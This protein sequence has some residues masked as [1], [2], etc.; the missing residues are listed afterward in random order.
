MFDTYNK[1]HFIHRIFSDRDLNR[2]IFLKTLF[3]LRNCSTIL[4]M[5]IFIVF[6]FLLGVIA[7]VVVVK[8]LR[9]YEAIHSKWSIVTKSKVNGVHTLCLSRHRTL[10][11][12]FSPFQYWQSIL[13][14]NDNWHFNPIPNRID[15]EL[16]T[17][18]WDSCT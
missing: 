6:F 8:R 5:P 2:N 16:N 7:V 10:H 14:N 15:S 12:T 13:C 18:E 1:V 9:L 11:W 4:F 17:A 3:G